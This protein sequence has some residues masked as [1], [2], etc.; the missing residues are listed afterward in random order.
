M[1][2]P[3][4][5]PDFNLLHR[6]DRYKIPLNA[7]AA[8]TRQSHSLWHALRDMVSGGESRTFIW[9]SAENSATGFV[10]LQI[11][12]EATQA[13]LLYIGS[14]TQ[15]AVNDPSVDE[16]AWLSILDDVIV[17][18]GKLGVYSI[19]AEAPENGPELPILRHAGFA[20]YTRQDVWVLNGSAELRPV[21]S[22][23]I[24]AGPQDN[25]DIELLYAHTVPQMIQLVEPRPPFDGVDK[26][27][28]REQGEL[29]AYAH[30][31]RGA[32]ASWLRL[33]VHPNAETTL[34]DFVAAIAKT[35]PPTDDRPIFCR[36]RRSQHWL[37]GT[38]KANGFEYWGSQAVMVK[39][40]VH[41]VKKPL[42]TLESIMQEERS[43][44]RSTPA[45]QKYKR[46]DHTKTKL[47]I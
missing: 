9:K 21:E 12:E 1:I 8:L 3:F 4:Q 18:S 25:W 2:R 44:A 19:V 33:F 16:D 7:E 39:H 34:D 17:E 40:T 11:N 13:Y 31:Q 46:D 42:R 43:T 30:L 23:L 37:E 5:L 27:V 10:Q 22:E 20:V 24:S 29:V 38:L 14:T 6:L 45:V 28:W 41:H 26:W 35:R 15:N 32:D 36:L 47:T